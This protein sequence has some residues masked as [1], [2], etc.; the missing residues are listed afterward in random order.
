MDKKLYLQISAVVVFSF[1]LVMGVVSF[2]FHV[3]LFEVFERLISGHF[4]SDEK[5]FKPFF[6]K[7]VP[8]NFLYIAF[9]L[10]VS[11]LLSLLAWKQRAPERKILFLKVLMFCMPALL[12]INAAL[13]VAGGVKHLYVEKR[14]FYQ[15]DQ[16]A[17]YLELYGWMYAYPLNCQ[18]TLSGGGKARLI[19]DLDPTRDPGMIFSRIVAYHM[20]PVDLRDVRP[21]DVDA[22][23]FYRKTKAFRYLEE[24]EPDF[25]PIHVFDQTS[26]I[27]V[28][29]DETR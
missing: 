8:I 27:A 21:G 20:Y 18:K 12:S 17:K 2:V 24:V 19:S 14:G 29:K 15:K 26:L 16:Q 6:I 10:T 7:G 25:V 28:R 23:L 4:T 5:F 22:L 11:A 3:P 13:Q 9:A 1:L